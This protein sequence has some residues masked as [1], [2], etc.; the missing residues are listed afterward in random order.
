[1][2][3]RW[4]GPA[5]SAESFT[6]KERVRCAFVHG[7]WLEL[8]GRERAGLEG[9]T[10]GDFTFRNKCFVEIDHLQTLPLGLSN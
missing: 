10:T 9:E 4:E 6:R 5:R 7:T 2:H 1:M 8:K 3:R